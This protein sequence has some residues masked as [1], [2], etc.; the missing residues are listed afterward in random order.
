MLGR[1]DEISGTLLKIDPVGVYD[2]RRSVPE[3]IVNLQRQLCRLQNET[4]VGIHRGR[5]VVVEQRLGMVAVETREGRGIGRDAFGVRVRLGEIIGKGAGDRSGANDLR[6]VELVSVQVQRA[7]ARDLKRTEAAHVAVRLE[8]AVLH[9]TPVRREIVAGRRL[10]RDVSGKEN[11]RGRRGKSIRDHIAR[12]VRTRPV[13]GIRRIAVAPQAGPPRELGEVAGEAVEKTRVA[14][15]RLRAGRVEREGD[16]LG[17]CAPFHDA[18]ARIDLAPRHIDGHACAGG[19]REV[20]R[21][22]RAFASG[23][24]D[25]HAVLNAERRVVQRMDV[26]ARIHVNGGDAAERIG[27]TRRAGVDRSSAK[28]SSAGVR[29]ARLRRDVRARALLDQLELAGQRDGGVVDGLSGRHVQVKFARVRIEV[30]QLH[31]L[32]VAVIPARDAFEAVIAVGGRV[33]EVAYFRH[34]HLAVTAQVYISL[35][36]EQRPVLLVV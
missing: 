13:R 28:L 15:D 31:H 16:V 11:R 29:L 4:A 22:V 25:G 5:K 27:E 10:H 20:A 23:Q 19:E 3:V 14:D 32:E 34:H 18:C 9:D 2:L 36:V 7:A 12:G 26:E 1:S 35:G 21:V 30:F 6:G 33:A 17:L 24:V 8:D